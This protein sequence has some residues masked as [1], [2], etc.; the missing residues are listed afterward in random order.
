M[1][2]I[3][4]SLKLIMCIILSAIIFVS[5]YFFTIYENPTYLFSAIVSMV[6]SKMCFPIILVGVAI[7][8]LYKNKN[9][10]N[11]VVF[12]IALLFIGAFFSIF[13]ALQ[14]NARYEYVKELNAYNKIL[15]NVYFE[16]ASNIREVTRIR[17]AIATPKEERGFPVNRLSDLALLNALR[18]PIFMKHRKDEDLI[19]LVDLKNNIAVINNTLD[20]F[21]SRPNPS[22][23]FQRD[24]PLIEK[25]LSKIWSAIVMFQGNNSDVSN[26]IEK[27]LSPDFLEKLRKLGTGMTFKNST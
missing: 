5:M 27:N 25:I 21:S 3:K 24:A 26:E 12:K 17:K 15:R 20:T 11:A 7:F 8:I 1:N 23:L 10:Q 6:A 16:S 22:V 18:N 19:L 14:T 13:L 2:I 4:N 9:N